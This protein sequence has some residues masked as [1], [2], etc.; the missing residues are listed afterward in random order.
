[1]ASTRAGAEILKLT[2]PVTIH[3]FS[4]L[5]ELVEKPDSLPPILL[6]DLS[7]V[8]YIDSAALGSLVAIHVASEQSGR[9][10]ALVGANS[11]L[12]NLFELAYVR[13]FLVIYDSIE[14]AESHLI[15]A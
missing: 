10:Y 11:R 2:G 7:Q 12:K 15:P 9:K 4:G 6:I 14:E 5:Q 3:N 8:P 13:A 1:M